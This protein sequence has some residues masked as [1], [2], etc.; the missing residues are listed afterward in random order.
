VTITATRH[1][2]DTALSAYATGT[3]NA[4]STIPAAAAPATRATLKVTD[5]TLIADGTSSGAT[6]SLPS[7]A[8]AGPLTV[9]TTPEATASAIRAVTDSAPV[10]ASTA[11]V[12]AM[13][14]SRVSPAAATTRRG[15][16]SASAPPTGPSSSDGSA[17]AVADTP[18]ST[19][20]P[21]RVSTSRFCA[22]ICSHAP[23]VLTRF[24]AA[25]R[26]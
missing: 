9:L 15:H 13:T 24:A 2:N 4:P 21:V 10:A 8:V 17:L 20:D 6:S 19:G 25:H 5:P 26:W 22:T 14:A 1:R 12:A 23:M 18:A 7:S 11:V 3:P 16:R